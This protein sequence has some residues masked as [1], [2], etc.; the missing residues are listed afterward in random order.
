MP[1]PFAFFLATNEPPPR[2]RG[3]VVVGVVVKGTITY[4]KIP[5]STT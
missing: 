4:K 1:S 3:P 5:V 2:V